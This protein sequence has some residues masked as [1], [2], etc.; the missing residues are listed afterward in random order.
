[1]PTRFSRFL[2]VLFLMACSLSAVAEVLVVTDSRHPVQGIPDA[3]LIEL[4]RAA[5]IEAELSAKLP[6]DPERA[7]YAARQ[8]VQDPELQRRLQSAYQGIAEARS[9]NLAKVPAVVVDRR[10]VVY[11]DPDVSRAVARIETYR[12]MQP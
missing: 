2:S 7:A 3:R 1:M 12:R 4:D 9:L 5:R 6:A 10:Y 11:G 8:R